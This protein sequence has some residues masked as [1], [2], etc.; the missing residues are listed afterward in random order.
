MAHHPLPV[1]AQPSSSASHATPSQVALGALDARSPTPPANLHDPIALRKGRRERKPSQR[2]KDFVLS[3]QSRVLRTKDKLPDPVVVRVAA[4]VHDGGAEGSAEVSRRGQ[5]ETEQQTEVHWDSQKNSF[6]LFRR[7]FR[8]SP[9]S[10]DPDAGIYAEG[11]IDI[12]DDAPERVNARDVDVDLP[13]ELYAPFPNLSSFLMGSWQNNGN[14]LKSRSQFNS[15][16]NLLKSGLV[17]QSELINVTEFNRV[18]EQLDAEPAPAKE[19]ENDQDLRS[20]WVRS[21][22]TIPI[23]CHQKMADPGVRNWTLE[24]GFVHRNLISVIKEKIED[25][26]QFAQFHTD[27]YE[28][29]FQPREEVPEVRVHGELYSSPAFIDEH[30]AVQE[31]PGEP[32]CEL[33]RVVLGLVFGSDATQ[34]TKFRNTNLWPLYLAFGNHSKYLRTKASNKLMVPVAFFEKVRLLFCTTHLFSLTLLARHSS[35]PLSRPKWREELETRR[36]MSS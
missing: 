18:F 27:P 16:V 1:S 23:P 22:V 19:E 2:Y 4:E 31:G 3:S 9:P 10:R 34:L 26:E 12:Q 32:G 15:L 14:N 30:R 17:D 11:F 7:Y 8:R 29:Y 35:L 6:G 25:P 20:G 33:E 28:L 13:P 21:P 5:E 36:T 24:P